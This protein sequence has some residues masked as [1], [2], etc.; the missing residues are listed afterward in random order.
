MFRTPGATPANP[1]LT[2]LAT[3]YREGITTPCE[4]TEAYLA[5]IEP[6]P[7][8]RTV[9]ANRARAQARRAE[10][11]FEAG[12]DLGPLQGIPLAVKDLLDMEGEVSAA[13]SAALLAAGR[14]AETDAPLIARLDEAG[15]VFLGRTQMTEFAFSGLGLNPHFGTPGCVADPARVPGGSSSGS[16]VAVGSGMACA[17]LGSDTGGSVRVPAA[18][19]GLVGLKTTDRDLPTE[20][21]VPLSTT[22]D[23]V[24]P[25]ART[26][27]DA[28][29]LWRALKAWEPERPP[30][31]PGALTLWAPPTVLQEGL[32]PEVARTFDAAV[33]ALE[34]AG[35]TV[36]R[37]ELPVLRE[38]HELYGRY[39]SF[40]AH[41][42]LAM[43][44]D[45]LEREGGRVD[46]RVSARILAVRGRPA[47]DYLRLGYARTRLA[48]TFWD[49]A[50]R[51]DAVIAPTVQI[52][53]PYREPLERSDE[54][55]VRANAA[56]LR[57]TTLF[58][59]ASGPAVQVSIGR[60]EAGI[61][62]GGMVAAPPGREPQV[63][64]VATRWQEALADG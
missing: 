44:E 20:G 36:I 35:H 49:E 32:D 62:V 7:V 33:A 48:R 4:A 40:A 14:V 8:F 18:F 5:R 30:V 26:V 51:A 23:T 57:N 42:A 55:Y 43:Y 52:E 28:W 53:P 19:Q 34:A 29:H 1:T 22:L 17:A 11:A 45:L 39:G 59:L 25:I 37:D 47:T 6:G 46:P 13:G 50:R 15:A 27:E 3:A 41:E 38:L 64:A 60:S 10:R 12:V 24:G 54:A 21:V 56:V 2:E 9:T 31:A 61:P 63:L 16:S 58:N